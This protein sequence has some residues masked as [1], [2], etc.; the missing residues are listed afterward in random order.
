MVSS[1]CRTITSTLLV[2]GAV[3]CIQ[4]QTTTQ[5]IANASI[6]G[7][8]TING[9]PAVGV[10]IIAR[11]SRDGSSS[12]M[13][14]HRARTDQTGSYRIT[15]LSAGTY[16]ISTITPAL[17]PANQSDSVVVADGEEV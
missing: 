14:S 17:V 10:V 3:V 9:K 15:N 4:A 1:A 5:K 6:S 12:M 7:K 13:R 16:A 11:D 2:L 8:V